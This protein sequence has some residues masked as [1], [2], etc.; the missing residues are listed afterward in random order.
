MK[1]TLKLVAIAALAATLSGCLM[2]LE[3]DANVSYDLKSKGALTTQA[4][5]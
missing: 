3:G 1:L 4:R 2:Y 5:G